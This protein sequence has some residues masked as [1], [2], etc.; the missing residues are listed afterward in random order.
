MPKSMH[1]ARI[2]AIENDDKTYFCFCPKCGKETEHYTNKTN[3]HTP[4]I[5]R[6]S[7]CISCC[8]KYDHQRHGT[9]ERREERKWTGIEEKY[10]MDK[11]EWFWMYKEQSGKCGM[12]ER[13]LEI[14][15]YGKGGVGK[16]LVACVDHDHETNKIRGM[17]CSRCNLMLGQAQK[18]WG[19]KL[20]SANIYLNDTR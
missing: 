6:G 1:P 18:A 5:G 15:L 14:T 2:K 16:S 17:L 12:C 4:Q 3:K 9:P 13:E 20:E 10:G 8:K 7:K 11:D 19:P